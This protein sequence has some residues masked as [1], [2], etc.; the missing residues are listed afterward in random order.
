[1]RGSSAGLYSCISFPHTL[2]VSGCFTYIP[3]EFITYMVHVAMGPVGSAISSVTNTTKPG[4]INSTY[5]LYAAYPGQ[6]FQLLHHQTGVVIPR[7]QHYVSGDPALNSSYSGGWNAG[8][9]PSAGEIREPVAN[10]VHDRQGR[11]AGHADSVHLVRRDHCL[12]PE[13]FRAGVRMSAIDTLVTDLQKA[14]A[15][16]QLLAGGIA[17]DLHILASR[18]AACPLVDAT[19]WITQYKTVAPTSIRDITDAWNG[20]AFDYATGTMHLVVHWRPHR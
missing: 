17:N 1:M 6:D 18:L 11:D 4:F 5:E 19:S 16:A 15:D 9:A 8:T 14:V 2:D 12:T 7:G 3:D 20:A 10:A 13:N